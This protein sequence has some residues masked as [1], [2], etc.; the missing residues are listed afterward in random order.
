MKKRKEVEERFMNGDIQIVCA[1]F[2]AISVG[3]TSG[4]VIEYSEAITVIRHHA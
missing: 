3:K 2:Q 1:S 4:F